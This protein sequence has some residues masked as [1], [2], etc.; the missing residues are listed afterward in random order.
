MKKRELI[1]TALVPGSHNQMSLYHNGDDYSISVDGQ[2]LMNTRMHGSEE[3]LAELGC[4]H[5]KGR[6]DGRILVGGLGMG[7]T[8][9]AA[10]RHAGPRCQVEVSELVPAVHSWNLNHYGA[11]AN[12]PLRDARVQVSLR[13]VAELLRTSP[14]TYDAILM[15]VDNGPCGM[16]QE[17]NSWLY[18]NAGLQITLDALKPQG[19]VAIWSA[20]PDLA[21]FKRLKRVGQNVSEHRVSARSGGG[22][23][24]HTIWVAQSRNAG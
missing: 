14:G 19:I 1:E 5:L 7:F 22:N 8:L 12:H 21:F 16:T 24:Y 4:Q 3:S 23:G 11:F 15:D 10:L 6:P 13:D 17:K 2:E 18:G 9:A 20:Y